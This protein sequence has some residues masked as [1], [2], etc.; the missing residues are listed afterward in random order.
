M[1]TIE[2]YNANIRINESC[3]V[4]DT[5]SVEHVDIDI[6]DWIEVFYCFVWQKEENIAKKN[7][8]I[9]IGANSKFIGTSVLID[10]IDIEIITEICGDNTTSTLDIL[11]LAIDSTNIWAQGVV[12]VK[13]PYRH[14][15]TRVDQTNILI[16]TWARVRGIPRLEISTDD[17]EGGH[18][19]RV[20]RLGGEALFYLTSRGLT[21]HHAE[22]LLLNSE[23]RRHLRTVEES[24]MEKICYDIHMRIKK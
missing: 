9:K 5:G 10:P 2:I 7:R 17:I 23:I 15:S 18:S 12:R 24:N 6:A 21:T 13:E 20:H 4:Y 8:H 11:A 14:V 19:C 16:G 3:Y 22:A 1:K